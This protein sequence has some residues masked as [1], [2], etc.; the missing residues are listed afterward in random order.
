[1]QRIGRAARNLAKLGEAIL[2]VPKGI[3]KTGLSSSD[4]RDLQ[5]QLL[6]EEEASNA[7]EEE[8]ND[9]ETEMENIVETTGHEFRRLDEGGMRVEEGGENEEVM[10]GSS[11]G[12]KKA[13]TGLEAREAAFLTLYANTQSCLRKVWNSYFN[14]DSKRE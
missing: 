11:R 4:V 6:D 3:R 10:G 13:K 12:R 8:A 14:N 9:G 2:L 5:S 7:D 1:M